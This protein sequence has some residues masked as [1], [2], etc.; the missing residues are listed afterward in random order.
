MICEEKISPRQHAG[1]VH[2]FGGI[3]TFFPGARLVDF[4]V[5]HHEQLGVLAFQ[6]QAK[7][8]GEKL[9]VMFPCDYETNVRTAMEKALVG[10]V[11][12]I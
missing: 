8:G 5:S 7:L 1:D 11:S 6:V 3:I 10:A 9:D 2:R 4:H 12:S